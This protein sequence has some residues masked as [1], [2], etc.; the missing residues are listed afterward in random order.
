MG[1]T[2]ILTLGRWGGVAAAVLA[3]GCDRASEAKDAKDA[4]AATTAASGASGSAVGVAGGAARLPGPA[5]VASADGSRQLFSEITAA[6][7]FNENPDRYP[8]GTY[9]TPEITPGGV[10]LFDCDND[11]RLD[12]LVI[13]HPPPM[14]YEKMVQAT[15]PNRLFK[16]QADGR[17]VEVP[18]AAGLAGKGFHHGV[19]IG[20]VNNDGWQDVYVCNYGGADEFFM[21]NGDGTF[22]DATAAAK[23]PT[24]ASPANWSS[25]A[26]FFDYDSDGHLDLWVAHFAT[27]NPKQRCAVSSDRYRSIASRSACIGGAG[28]R[29]RAG[30]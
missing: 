18:G 24:T 8:D 14:P 22:R 25:T 29:T 28:R 13:C 2:R 9:M 26:A 21:N 4:G 16:Q 27:F 17:F 12:V 19:A 7:G 30:S 3:G 11:G 15:A 5:P 10:A 23:L 1:M 6:A 20:D